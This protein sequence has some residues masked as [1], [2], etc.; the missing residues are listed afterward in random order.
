MRGNIKESTGIILNQQVLRLN[1][2]TQ[3]HPCCILTS[4][5]WTH[6]TTVNQ[7]DI[8]A[9]LV[10]V[11]KVILDIREFSGHSEM[12]DNVTHRIIK[13]SGEG[14]QTSQ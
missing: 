3:A 7:C 13:T 1:P 14:M 5:V 9:Q 11:T 12:E 10:K 2:C 6:Y 8:R 4:E